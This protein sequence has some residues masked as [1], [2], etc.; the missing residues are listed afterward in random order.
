MAHR[1]LAPRMIGNM[2]AEIT[3]GVRADDVSSRLAGAGG[4]GATV[5]PGSTSQNSQCRRS[6]RGPGPP[7][8]ASSSWVVQRCPE[9]GTHWRSSEQILQDAGGFSVSG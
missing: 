4:E 6:G 9:G 3:R 7:S 5:R 2:I 8:A 1:G